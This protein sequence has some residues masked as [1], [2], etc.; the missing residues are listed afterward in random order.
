MHRTHA[1]SYHDEKNVASASALSR[2]L[3]QRHARG[4]RGNALVE[5]AIVLPL[6]MLLVTGMATFGIALNQYLEL[7]DAVA[8]GAQDLA[9]Q[10][11]NTTDPCAVTSGVIYNAAPFL[12]SANM[13]LTY[14]LDGTTYGP[15]KG[16]AAN[17]C[18]ST[19]TG[20]GA[21]GNLLQ[22]DPAEVK[23]TYPCTLAV[24]GANILPGCTLQAEVTEIVQ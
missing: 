16:S 18:S 17:T 20:T 23:A 5:F 4:E 14:V 9:T 19:T 15:Y 8:I 6:F 7:N 10:R 24:Y 21:A 3:T 11:A 2:K 22:G 13:S 1:T 12:N